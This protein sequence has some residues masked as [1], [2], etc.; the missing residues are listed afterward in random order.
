[1][2]SDDED[3]LGLDLSRHATRRMRLRGISASDVLEVI[4]LCP[5]PVDQGDGRFLFRAFVDNRDLGVVRAVDG[6]IVTVLDFSEP[7]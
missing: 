7:G 1:V 5:Q 2:L 3:V 6:V 4:A